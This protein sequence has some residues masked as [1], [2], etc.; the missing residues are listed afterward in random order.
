MPDRK[1]ST[2]TYA[3]LSFIVDYGAIG[4][5]AEPDEDVQAM[6]SELLA[7]R[8]RIEALRSGGRQLGKIVHRLNMTALDVTGLHHLI[9]EDGDGDWQAVWENVSDL[10]RANRKLR[11]ELESRRAGW[12]S[13]ARVITTVEELDA[14]PVGTVLVDQWRTAWCATQSTWRGLARSRPDA[15]ERVV[16]PGTVLWTPDEAN[17]ESE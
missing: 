7:A 5:S 14:L 2:F 16:L 4:L 9:D 8:A 11:A 17:G 1:P 3:A 15:P 6:A 12:R 10:G 13:P